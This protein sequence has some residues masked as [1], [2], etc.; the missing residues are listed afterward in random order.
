MKA[1]MLLKLAKLDNKIAVGDLSDGYHTYNELYDHRIHLFMALCNT[2]KVVAWKSRKHCD[3]SFYRGFFIAGLETS[4][5][6]I[7]YHVLDKYWDLFDV[8]ELKTAETWDGHTSADVLVRLRAEYSERSK[9]TRP[10]EHL[11]QF[12]VNQTAKDV[13]LTEQAR[14]NLASML[15]GLTKLWEDDVESKQRALEDIDGLS[16]DYDEND[17]DEMDRTLE[18]INEIVSEFS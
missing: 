3:G 17:L 9:V 7:T 5:G 12:I 6:Q 8:K 11:V 18:R 14:N 4:A 2:N 10:H 15:Y 16:W 13:E 1:E